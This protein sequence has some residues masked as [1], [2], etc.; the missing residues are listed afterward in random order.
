MIEA[1]NQITEWVNEYT[2]SLYNWALLKVN[3]PAL[4][5]DLV[6]DTF[7]AAYT[8]ISKFQNKSQ[9]KTWLL[10]ILKNK[11]ADHYRK[12]FKM[13][14]VNESEI[15][16]QESESILDRFFNANGEWRKEIRPGR[17]DDNESE[18]LDNHEFL[19]ILKKCMDMLNEKSYL[20]IQYKFIEEKESKAICQELGITPS[21][22]WQL[23]HRAKLQLRGCIDKNWFN[24]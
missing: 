3:K 11:I 6:Q 13:H 2:D 9:P 4:A 15:G 10:S 24:N 21:N 18:L 19:I 22:F 17:W 1:K 7:L 23:L 5:E 20:S 16:G 14:T 8:S 12:Q